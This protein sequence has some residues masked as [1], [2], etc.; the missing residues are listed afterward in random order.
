MHSSL[1]ALLPWLSSMEC[2]LFCYFQFF[3][4]CTICLLPKRENQGAYMPGGKTC[5]QSAEQ[6]VM[7]QGTSTSV[8]LNEFGKERDFVVLS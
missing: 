5:L 3:S 8:F 4:F 2:P 6:C 1:E 7:R